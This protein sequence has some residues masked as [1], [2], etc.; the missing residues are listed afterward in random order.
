MKPTHLLLFLCLAMTSL[1]LAAQE[2]YSKVKIWLDDSHTLPQLAKLGLEVEHGFQRPGTWFVGEFSQSEIAA[3]NAAGFSTEIMI[4]DLKAHLLEGNRN[5]ASTLD[6]ALPPCGPAANDDIQTPANYT[7][8]SMAGYL[9]YDEMLA[10]LDEMAALYPNLFKAKAPISTTLNTIEGRPIYWVKISDNPNADE[11]DEPEIFFNALHHAREPNS[12]SQMIFFMWYLLENYDTDPGVKFLVD[13]TEIYLVPCVNP[14]GYVY[15]ETTNP[16]G[17][18]YWRKNRRP[19]ADGSYG[20][21]LN[22]NYAYQWGY[23]DNGSSS[24]PSSEIYRGTGPFSEPETQ[25]IR[26]FSLE[27]DFEMVFNFHTFSNLLVNSWGYTLEQTPDHDLMLAYGDYMTEENGY[28]NGPAPEVL[29][30]VNGESNDWQ[31]GEQVE[32][33]KSY[34]FV[35]EVGYSF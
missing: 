7:P 4:P 23:D 33:G 3:V 1:Q 16:D 30:F 31:Y 21:D 22:R 9:K 29:Y 12:M 25:L 8:G 11:T 13:H 34:S 20:V 6:R 14:D 27:H 28:V 15:N 5:G 2:R 35:P 10:V 17:G 26:Q 18:G 32:K 19:N 24:D